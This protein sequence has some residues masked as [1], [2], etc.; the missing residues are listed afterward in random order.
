MPKRLGK[1]DTWRREGSTAP[2]AYNLTIE[3]IWP[4]RASLAL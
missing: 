4:E 3:A 1:L 2:Y